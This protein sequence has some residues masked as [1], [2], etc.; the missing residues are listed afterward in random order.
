[1]VRQGLRSILEVY[2]DIS[3][4]GEAADG[5]EVVELAR[6]LSPDVVVMDVNMPKVD[7]IEA[8][9]RIKAQQPAML[10]VGL[11][12]SESKQVEPLLLQAGA[13]SYVSKDAACDRLYEA[14]ITVMKREM[15]PD[16]VE[17][18]GS[19]IPNRELPS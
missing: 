1:M 6:H 8:I 12:L 2:Q 4:I 16:A 14:I 11:S 3:V 9:R 13:S 19:A 15:S 7:G 18:V 17:N 10:I 5:E